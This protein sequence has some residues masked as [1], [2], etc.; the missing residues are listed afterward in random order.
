ML[1][2]RLTSGRSIWSCDIHISRTY[3]CLIEG[4]PDAELNEEILAR[5]PA[6]V[7]DAFFPGTV[8]PHPPIVERLGEALM[9][10][11]A[12]KPIGAGRQPANGKCPH[13]VIPPRLKERR[14]PPSWGGGVVMQLPA[15]RVMAR[16][17]SAAIR[18]DN[19]G[20]EL[21]VVWFQDDP[22]LPE[23][24]EPISQVALLQ[25]E[26]APLVCAIDWDRHARDYIQ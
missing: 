13:V 5:V 11:F 23:S 9:K 3:A 4:L 2:V 10:W 25:P 15:V 14:L 6:D 19:D 1:D 16:F 20:S 7:A 17:K 8:V 26:V 12:R 22:V 18:D 24:L 21:V